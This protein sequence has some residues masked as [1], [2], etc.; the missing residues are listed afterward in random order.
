M[1]LADKGQTVPYHISTRRLATPN[2]AKPH[3]SR[4]DKLGP[5]LTGQSDLAHLLVTDR[6][7]MLHPTT[8]RACALLSKLIRSVPTLACIWLGSDTPCIA[9]PSPNTATRQSTLG[10]GDS[11]LPVPPNQTTGHTEFALDQPNGTGFSDAVL[12]TARTCPSILH[13]PG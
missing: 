8:S 6:H 3:A 7:A 11:H 1:R 4:P 2:R 9:L 12:Y 10:L 5:R 13:T